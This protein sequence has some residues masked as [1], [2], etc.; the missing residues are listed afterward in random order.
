[1]TKSPKREGK[2]PNL[3]HMERQI[4]FRI[5][6]KKNNDWLFGYKESGG[7][8]LLGEIVMLGELSAI[9]LER[10]N[11]LVVMQ[12]TGLLDRNGKEIY[13]GDIVSVV[14]GNHDWYA[15]SR[16]EKVFFCEVKYSNQDGCFYYEWP[17]AGPLKKSYTLEIQIPDEKNVIGKTLSISS[18]SYKKLNF[19]E[20]ERH[21][22]IILGSLTL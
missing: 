22:A 8:S 2:K 4:K 16:K 15:K 17:P 13:E 11:D 7:F 12:F 5:W 6:D 21:A 9:R 3:I 20:I 14:H 19:A 18:F 10:L 1:M